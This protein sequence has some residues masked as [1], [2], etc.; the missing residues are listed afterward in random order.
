[1]KFN[2]FIKILFLTFIGIFI[3]EYIIKKNTYVK[4]SKIEGV[5][6]FAHKNFKKG[7][8]VLCEIFPNKPENKILFNPISSYDF[9]KYISYEGKNINHC[10]NNFNTD[11]YINNYKEF[12][13]IAI[14]DIKTDEEIIAN[15]DIIHKKLPF[16]APSK[17]TYKQC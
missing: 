16:I 9:N 4:T 13:L 12:K 5:G 17:P 11:I 2:N 14:K 10:S 3:Y 6:L 1:M 8:V 15:Y 7:D